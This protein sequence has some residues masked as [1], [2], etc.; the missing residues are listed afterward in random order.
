MSIFKYREKN[1]APWQT[2]IVAQGEQGIP[3]EKGD[4]GAPFTYE[5]FTAE[6]LAALKGESGVY[7]GTTEPEDESLIWINPEAE[8]DDLATKAYVD[9]AIANAGG[10]GG[11]TDLSDYYTKTEVDNLIPT[12]PTQVSELENDAGY[13]TEHQSL[14]AYALKTEI[15]DVSSYTTMAAVE[16]KGYQT[17]AQVQALINT[18]LTEVE[19]GSY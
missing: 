2:L 15:P 4:T 3:G 14:A 10:G 18:A 1:G 8:S 11:G 16:A 9:E 13:L 6:Q 19:N 5:D 7:V 12:V 17:A